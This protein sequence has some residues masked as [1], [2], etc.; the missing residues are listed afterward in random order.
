MKYVEP[1]LDALVGD[2]QKFLA[3]KLFCIFLQMKTSESR[4]PKYDLNNPSWDFDDNQNNFQNQMDTDFQNQMGTNLPKDYVPTIFPYF[5]GKAE[6]SQRI[7]I[8]TKS[9]SSIF[10]VFMKTTSYSLAM[11]NNDDYVATNDD[12]V[13]VPV[14][15]G[16]HHSDQI[17]KAKEPHIGASIAPLF[18]R[19]PEICNVLL[20]LDGGGGWLIKW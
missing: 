1:I 16:C 15:D 6:N 12:C 19:E 7:I 11:G 3:G 18:D 13:V 2:L 14:H 20:A 8:E 17:L 4:V 9:L 5:I 10:E